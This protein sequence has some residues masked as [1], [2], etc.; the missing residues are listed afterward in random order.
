MTDVL[1]MVRSDEDRGRVY[2]ISRYTGGAEIADPVNGTLRDFERVSATLERACESLLK[3]LES[4][5][6]N[7]LLS[8]T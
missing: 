1:G 7:A 3:E 6:H 5:A 8:V 4:R 2:P